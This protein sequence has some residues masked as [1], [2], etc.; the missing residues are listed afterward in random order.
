LVQPTFHA[1]A[2]PK[3]SR[4]VRPFNFELDLL[5]HTRCACLPVKLARCNRSAKHSNS[6]IPNPEPRASARL[7]LRQ[8][9][10]GHGQIVPPPPFR[11]TWRRG[12]VRGYVPSS[13][14]ASARRRFN[15]RH[16]Q[17]KVSSSQRCER[18]GSVQV[19]AS[20]PEIAWDSMSEVLFLS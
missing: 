5:R 13:R 2:K 9:F 11:D 6:S 17:P 4:V 1:F 20:A 19:R 12:V 3:P 8:V 16:T 15:F 10:R 7:P 18:R 14:M